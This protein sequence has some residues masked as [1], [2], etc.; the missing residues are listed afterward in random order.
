MIQIKT[1]NTL[2]LRNLKHIYYGRNKTIKK[3]LRRNV[4]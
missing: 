1:K 2:L 4:K 3:T